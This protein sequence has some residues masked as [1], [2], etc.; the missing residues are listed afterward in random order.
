MLLL[1]CYS[2]KSHWQIYWGALMA[3]WNCIF[4]VFIPASEFYLL[5]VKCS[6]LNF[7]LTQKQ[8]VML[9][10]FCHYFTDKLSISTVNFCN[11]DKFR[12]RTTGKLP[13][14]RH[15]S[16]W[17]FGTRKFD[18]KCLVQTIWNR[19]EKVRMS[20]SFLFFSCAWIR[21]C[22]C[23]VFQVSEGY[24]VPVWGQESILCWL[25]QQTQCKYCR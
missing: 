2:L 21:D 7:E 19:N 5:S 23:T 10:L 3:V 14:Y 12:F 1:L 17:T 24:P 4:I 18:S 6:I 25:R 16:F 11:L 9:C 20:V 13:V 22:N 15:P 8:I